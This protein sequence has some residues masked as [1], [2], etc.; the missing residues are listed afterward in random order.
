MFNLKAENKALMLKTDLGV[1]EEFEIL[2]ILE[3]ENSSERNQL[4]PGARKNLYKEI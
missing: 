1:S 3:S 2:E 4:R